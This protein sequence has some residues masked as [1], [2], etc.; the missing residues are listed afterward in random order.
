MRHFPGFCLVL[1]LLTGCD[2]M[3]DRSRLLSKTAT[4]DLY[5]VSPTQTP[6]S[7]EVT[8][9]ATNATLF[10]LRP[11]VITAADVDTV[12]LTETDG[13][14]PS[15][16]VTLTPAGA[17]KLAAAT[18]NPTGMQLAFLINGEVISTPKLISPLSAAF[19]VTGEPI[20]KNGQQ[21]FESITK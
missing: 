21:L 16:S 18:A 11:A 7:L 19:N 12:Q 10:L 8:D 5:I 2:S 1:L 17:T 4:L 20:A 15:L 13:Q 6:D 9:P 3:V 14:P